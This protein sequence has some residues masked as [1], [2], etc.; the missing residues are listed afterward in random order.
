M[1]ET[2]LA[3]RD[4]TVAFPTHEGDVRAVSN[5]SYTLHRGETLGIV[6]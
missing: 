6:G 3:V 5:L 1:S 4:L 2:L